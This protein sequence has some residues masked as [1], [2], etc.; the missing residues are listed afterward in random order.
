MGQTLQ[1]TF[2]G[3]CTAEYQDHYQ[4]ENMGAAQ[5]LPSQ[6]SSRVGH[7]SAAKEHNISYRSN[8]NEGKLLGSGAEK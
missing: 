7:A 6:Q 5:P 3:C 4:I 1:T 8:G 2:G